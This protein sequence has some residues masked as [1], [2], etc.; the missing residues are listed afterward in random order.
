MVMKQC[1]E[2]EKFYLKICYGKG[3][4]NISNKFS[5]VERLWEKL[6]ILQMYEIILAWIELQT[7]HI[8]I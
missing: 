7:S 1:Q 6:Y 4:I 3:N 2:K 8:H 5:Y